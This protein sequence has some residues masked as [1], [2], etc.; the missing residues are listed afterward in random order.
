[1]NAQWWRWLILR[2]QHEH[3]WELRVA[4]GRIWLACTSCP[5]ETPGWPLSVSER[6]R[7]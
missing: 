1:M 2:W 4:P 6:R 5:A 3:T 7:V